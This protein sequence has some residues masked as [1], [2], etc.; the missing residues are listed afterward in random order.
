MTLA[1]ARASSGRGDYAP[2]QRDCVMI[3]GRDRQQLTSGGVR[4]LG[5]DRLRSF[6]GLLRLGVR[7]RVAVGWLVV[8]MGCRRR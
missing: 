5:G 6:V 4:R 3:T 8:V 2:I 1:A 7:A